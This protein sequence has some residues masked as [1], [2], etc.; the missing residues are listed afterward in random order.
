MVETGV[1]LHLLR[2]PG[3]RLLDEWLPLAAVTSLGVG[4]AAAMAGAASGSLLLVGGGGGVAALGLLLLMAG[5]HLDPLVALALILPLPALY[6]TGSLRLAPAAPMTAL[7]ISAWVLGLPI[8]T[9]DVRQARLPALPIFLLLSAFGLAGL[10]SAYP[11]DA[12]REMVNLCVL[13]LLLFIATDLVARRPAR[14][15]TLVRM[16]SLV[17]A[18]TGAF[19]VLETVGVLPGRFPEPAGYNRAA[20]GFGQPNGLGMFLALSLP[21]VVYVRRVA[22]GRAARWGASIALAATLGGLVGTFSRGSWLSVLVGAAILPLA[23]QWRFTLRIWGVALLIAVGV[24]FASGGL[25]REV[26]FG[27]LEDWSI[28]QRAALMLAGLEMFLQNPLLGVGPGGFLP[29]LERSGALIP[30]LWDLKPTPHNA[31]IQM[32]AEAGLVGLVAFLIFL[33]AL[34]RQSVRLARAGGLRRERRLHEAVLWA[35]AIALAEG[36]VEWPFSHGHG[37]LVMMTAALACGLPLAGGALNE[38][39]PNADEASS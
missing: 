5:E 25:V 26:V 4:L 37:Q 20:L 10:A 28:V 12:V 18:V 9:G 34:F 2:P 15:I 6:A 1:R 32:A 3:S 33:G 39:G 29:E 22:D 7:I 23:G 38:A 17:A 13:L 21:F 35:L 14:A 24:D 16:L 11:G 31:Y 8:R 30:Q 36:M 27:I 19:A